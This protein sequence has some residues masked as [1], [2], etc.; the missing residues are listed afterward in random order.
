MKIYNVN[1]FSIDYRG[2]GKLHPIESGLVKKTLFGVKEIITDT[3]LEICNENYQPENIVYD[4][5]FHKWKEYGRILAVDSSELVKKNLA[6]KADIDKYLNNWHTSR[7]KGIF[8][9]M[10]VTHTRNIEYEKQKINIKK[11]SKMF[12]M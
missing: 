7:L 6:T 2:N 12:N 4:F 9:E 10:R 8:E 11:I 3:E 5:D 1:I